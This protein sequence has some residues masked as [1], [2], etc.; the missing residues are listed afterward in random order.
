MIQA[1][2]PANKTSTLPNNF[3]IL[4]KLIQYLQNSITRTFTKEELLLQ[5]DREMMINPEMR[6][7]GTQ[8]YIVQGVKYTD[9][10]LDLAEHK[11]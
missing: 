11:N 8:F 9:A 4:L 2:D 6:S 1:G 7:S 5:Q 3:L 10:D